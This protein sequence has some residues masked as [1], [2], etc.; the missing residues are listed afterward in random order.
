MTEEDR[1][2]R[3]G[4]SNLSFGKHMDHLKKMDD[5]TNNKEADAITER[6]KIRQAEELILPPQLATSSVCPAVAH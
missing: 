1:G 4:I 5:E 6:D 3:L 2:I